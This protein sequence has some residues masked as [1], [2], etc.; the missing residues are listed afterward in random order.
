MHIGFITSDLHHGHGWGHY[1]LALLHALRAKGVQVSAVAASNSPTDYAF[2]V[3]PLLPAVVPAEPRQLIKLMNRIQPTRRALQTADLIHCTIEAYA[4]LAWALRHQRYIITAHG[5]YARAGWNRPPPIRWLHRRS[6]RGAAR[7]VCVSHY[8]AQV[9]QA[10][11]P[12]LPT[13][14]VHSGI[15]PAR[16]ATLP[17]LPDAPQRPIILTVGGIK[18]RKG[19]PQLIRA[20]AAIRQQVPDV[21]CVVLGSTTTEPHTT[22]A[23]HRLIDQYHLADHVRLLGFVDEPTLHAWYGAADVFVL[24]SINDGYKFEGFGLVHLEASAAGLPVIG[25]DN[26]GAAD[27]IQHEQTG[28]LLRQA[29]LDEDLPAALLRLLQNPSEAARM[30][31]A[32]RAYAQKQTW[33]ATANRMIELYEQVLCTPR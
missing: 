7:V 31:A 12:G 26:C 18:K 10:D 29:Q 13:V 20:I 11:M 23:V 33:D 16:F 17:A 30:G 24:P 25:A 22:A 27:A 19:T 28:L 4:P 9:A 1:S 6:F 15:D 21:L 3:A 2:P 14:T 5:T 32:G 8:T